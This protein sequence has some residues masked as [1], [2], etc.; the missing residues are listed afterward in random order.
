MVFYSYNLLITHTYSTDAIVLNLPTSATT[1]S[2]VPAVS[3]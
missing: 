3:C 2:Y 1:M